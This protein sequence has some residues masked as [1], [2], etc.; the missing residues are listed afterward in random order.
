MIIKNALVMNIMKTEN[1]LN[2]T[3]EM[4]ENSLESFI[5]APIVYNEMGTFKD[6]KDESFNDYFKKNIVIGMILENVNIVNDEVRADILIYDG[7]IN[8]WADRYNNW[9]IKLAE[10]KK[11]FTVD[12]IE[13]F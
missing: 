11:S 8:L 13:V 5:N 6:Y 2:I 7:Y 12:S 3:K 9:C 10:D 1:G 4:I